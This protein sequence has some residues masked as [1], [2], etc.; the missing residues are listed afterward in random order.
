VTAQAWSQT[1][2]DAQ[3]PA[4]QRPVWSIVVVS[5]HSL[6]MLQRY[7]SGLLAPDRLGEV[8][9]GEVEVVIVDNADQRDVADFA[10]AQGFRY[11]SMG[12][13]VGLSAANN[14]GAELS[15]GDY[16]LFANPDLGV[17]VCDLPVLRAHLD[18]T[19]GILT[20]RLDFPDGRPQ[21]AA[22]AEPYLLAK[23]AHRGVGPKSALEHYLWPVGP[24]ESGP[25]TWVAGGATAMSRATFGRVGGWPE[26]YFLYMEDVELG[27]RAGALGIPVSVTAD[28]RWVHEWRGDSR[29]RLN[30]GHVLHARSALRFYARH[31]RFLGWPR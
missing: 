18:R 22:R 10:A 31:P 4:G 15:Q 24:Y 20:P 28:V 27:I 23:L 26:E 29:R 13:N 6:T 5:Y 12:G 7:W 11:V 2:A 14:R 16:L 30:R 21:S 17:Q 8:A 25:V 3:P 19:E 1:F 9:P